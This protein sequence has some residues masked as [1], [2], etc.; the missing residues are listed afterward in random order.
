M[1]KKQDK[2]ASREASKYDNPIVSREWI[3]ELLNDSPLS[4]EQVARAAKMESPDNLEALNRRLRAMVRDGQLIRN[5]R[6]LFVVL[7]KADLIRGV[8]IGH[9]D[10]F[11]FV[12]PDDGGED[13]YLSS[14]Q[15]SRAMDGDEVIVRQSGVDRRGRKEGSVVE[16]VKRANDQLVGRFVDEG[17]L[18]YVLPDNP[19]LP[20]QVVI[21]PDETNNARDGEMVVVE[22]MTYPTKSHFATAKITHVL[23]DKMAPGMEIEIA[24]KSH[25]I[26]NEWPSDVVAET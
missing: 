7:N 17:Y 2:H 14:H 21:P 22:M 12:K 11:G 9:R 1:T 25:R 15:M 18:K 6:N 24:I 3:L 26:P 8:V 4:F 23:G 5:R 19:K 13:L 10:G 20:Q 16:V